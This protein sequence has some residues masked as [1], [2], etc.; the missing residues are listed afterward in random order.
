MSSVFHRVP[1]RSMP[2]AVRG[3]GMYIIDKDGNRYL[4]SYA[5]GA[6]VSNLG[7]SHL[8]II[9]AIQ[10]QVGQMAFFHGGMFTSEP[11]EELA[12]ILI[13]DAPS[14]LTRAFFSNSGSEAVET[15]LMMC[16]Q[17]FMETGQPNRTK[18]I[19]RRNSY[20]GAGLTGL[21]VGYSVARR[22]PFE[23]ILP[24]VFHISP[25]YE[26]RGR[27]EG[28]TS[29]QYGLRVANELEQAI[30]GLGA[31][32]VMAF[33]AETVVGTTSGPTPPVPGYFRRIREICD[34]YG[35]FLIMDE[36]L[37]G[38]GRTGSLHACEQ[39][40]VAPDFLTLAKGIAGGYQPLAATL[41]HQKVYDAIVGGSGS[42]K[43]GYTY[44]GHATAC[45][46]AVAAQ[47]FIRAPGFIEGV[48]K[49]GAHLGSLLQKRF[50][51]HSSVGDIRGRG[52]MMTLE[53]VEDRETKAPF[54]P[55]RNLGAKIYEEALSRGLITYALTGTVDGRVG[56]HVIICP[57]LIASDED[58]ETI[59]AVLGDTI[60]A[61]LD[62]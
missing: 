47:K 51:Q 59:V 58:V 4:D 8:E 46:A 9:K 29:E 16:R 60:D 20:H 30:L 43:G 11:L 54:S 31:G 37:C 14:G 1:K 48:K 26:Y 15:A 12:S 10:D 39:E 24:E 33:I 45:A 42:F 25:C 62:A 3:E 21:G 17:Y 44:S 38:L 52:L 57:P 34:K 18:V 32:T 41:I 28:E 55:S 7:H 56:D 35:V 2:T 61:V 6:S 13:S 53:L 27:Y 22:A 5:G 23:D 49:T 40:G 36:V 50:G 19:G